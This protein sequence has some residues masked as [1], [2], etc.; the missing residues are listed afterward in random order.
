MSTVTNTPLSQK[1]NDFINS[2]FE[3]NKGKFLF[4]DKDDNDYTDD[5]GGTLKKMIE[6]Y[7][8]TGKISIWTGCSE[9]SIFADPKINHKF[10]A[11]HDFH[12]VTKNLSFDEIG[13]KQVCEYQKNDLPKTYIF[14]RI[15]LD[16]EINGQIEYLL[17]KGNFVNN[18]IDF[19][20]SYLRG[21]IKEALKID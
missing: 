13:E 12:H 8:N 5:I 1:L 9:T 6:I 21:G 7:K 15:L 10:R 20:K 19:C 2:W 11:W 3:D 4:V 18:Q 14:E 17:K 16:I